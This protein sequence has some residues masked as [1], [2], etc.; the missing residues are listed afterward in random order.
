MILSAV[1][2]RC[3]SR[4]M[5]IFFSTLQI[6][7]PIPKWHT[8]R[9]WLLK[10]GHYKLNRLK[11]CANDWIWIVDHTV[12][13]GTEKCLLIL[14]IRKKDLPKK[15]ALSFEDLEPLE[16]LPV[17]RSDGT[18]VYDQLIHAASKTG[19]PRA[20]VSDGGPDLK[21]GIKK[22][23]DEH[24]Y[25]AHIYDIKH[26]MALCLKKTL[27][28]DTAWAGFTELATIAQR[29]MR[30][31][32]VAA[33]AP[34]N[35]RSKARYLNVDKLVNWATNVMNMTTERAEELFDT[36]SRNKSLGWLAYY[37]KDLETWS[38]IIHIANTIVSFITINGISRGVTNELR[39][40]FDEQAHCA[41]S[42]DFQEFVLGYV[43]LSEGKVYAGERLL[44]SSDIIESLFGKFKNLEKQQASSGFT[45]LLLALPGILGKTS[46]GIVKQAMEVTK[47]TQVWNWLKNNIGKSVQ[48]KRK[49][50]FA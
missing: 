30:Q 21:L 19:I 9:L 28:A 38:R 1:G 13:W 32:G 4:V 47:V 42:Y 10:L 36:E 33:L 26:R 2:L 14:G 46:S 3:V 20:I 17:T 39:L 6:S 12:Q 24:K 44:G 15:R 37:K 18:I 5:K 40:M 16:L 8:S 43:L 7:A 50:A 22:F 48:A 34:P 23:I 31:S 25:T 41:A 11:D 35:Q 45:S 29:Y 49:L 27:E